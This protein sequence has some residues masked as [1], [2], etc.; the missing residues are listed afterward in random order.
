LFADFGAE[1][2]KVEPAEGDALRSMGRRAKGKSLYAASLLRNKSLISLDLRT[3]EGQA[4]VRTLVA[5]CDVVVENFRPGTLEK[6]GLGYEDL[7]KVNSKLVMVRISGYGQSG[8]YKGRAGYGVICESVGGLRHLIGD[9]DRPPARVSVALT[10]Y[11]AGLYGFAGGV[12]ALLNCR[13]TGIGQCVD[14]A[15]YEAAFSLMEQ[16]I[17]AY[18]HLGI[19]PKRTGAASGGGVN[20]LYPTKDDEVIHIAANGGGVFKRLCAVLQ[21]LDLLEDARFNS[22]ALR[23]KNREALDCVIASWTR[24]H[25]LRELEE[26]LHS[27]AV[28]ASRIYTLADIFQDPHYRARET[29]VKVCDEDLGAVA[30]SAVVPRL[31]ATPGSIRHSG[32]RVGEDT[33]A[34]L[35]SLA[36]LTADDVEGL[37]TRKVIYCAQHTRDVEHGSVEK[38]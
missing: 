10:D 14:A 18:E 35:T 16:H 13:A 7:V 9:P 20:N 30:L 15:L 22:A 21:R 26:K 27:A 4:L 6:W 5:S 1:V 3:T 37:Q 36:N 24:L 19:V 34:V 25:T 31:S 33:A 38:D 32:R 11:V 29:I 23:N 12:L 2:I 17:A 8:P 28:P